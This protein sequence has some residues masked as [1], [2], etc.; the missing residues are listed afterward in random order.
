MD[1]PTT[2][3]ELYEALVG[4]QTLG[5]SDPMWINNIGT[6]SRNFFTDGYGVAGAYDKMQNFEPYTVVGGNVQFSYTSDGFKDYLTMTNK[7]YSEGLI[8]SDFASDGTISTISSSNAYSLILNGNM[9][10]FT[11]GELADLTKI[12]NEAEDPNMELVAMADL[13][14]NKGDTLHVKTNDTLPE[15]RWS[16]STSCAEEKYEIIC[17][18]IDWWFTEEGSD[19]ASWGIQGEAWNYDE[20]GDRRF[21]DLILNNPDNLSLK[22]VLT[23]YVGDDHPSMIQI[24]RSESQYSDQAL[25]A[26]DLWKSNIDGSQTYPTASTSMTVAESDAYNANFNDIITYA[27]ENIPK[28]MTGELSIESDWDKYVAAIEGMGLAEC[29]SYKQAAYERYTAK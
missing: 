28:F 9:G 27:Q 12:P 26:S 16:V 17:K 1:I 3:D 20:N 5:A 24:A 15:K 11:N 2:Y 10:F 18:Y 21:T 4:F 13:T 8:W 25:A 19:L 23:L 7:W 14:L 6:A 22:V 29:I